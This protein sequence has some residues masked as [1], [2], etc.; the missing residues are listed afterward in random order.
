[1]KAYAKA[2]IFL[3]IVGI[4]KRGYHLL[5]SRFIL[6]ENFYD[7]LSLTYEKTQDGFEIISDFECEDNIIKKAYHLLCK[8]GFERE[9]EECFK[10]LSLKLVKNIPTFAGLGGGSS[11]AACFL[12]M[13]NE[14]LNLKI[15][16]SKLMQLGLCLGA[17]VPFFLSGFFS[18]NVSGIGELV[19]EHEDV[20]P[21][22]DFSF[23]NVKCSTKAVY[24]EFDRGEF[25]F[26]ENLNLAKNMQKQSSKK[27][28]E[29]GQN[30]ILNDLFAP[31]V[32]IYADMKEFL[33]QGYFLSGSGS[34]VFKVAQ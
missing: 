13:M 31:C 18:A 29:E 20:I 30:A 2:N 23:P 33:D 9:L 25:D 21:R 3:K 4:D 26:Y 16:N 6:L 7:E 34:S 12:K 8:E 11:D 22:L 15:S 17:D 32:K 19:K 24:D 1:M 14:E 28:L 5:N 10:H 27:I